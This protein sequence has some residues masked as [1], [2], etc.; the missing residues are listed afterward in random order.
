MQKGLIITSS[1]LS[2]CSIKDLFLTELKLLLLICGPSVLILGLWLIPHPGSWSWEPID[3]DFMGNT[4]ASIGWCL[5]ENSRTFIFILL[6]YQAGLLLFAC[7]QAYILKRQ[8][9][10][11]DNEYSERAIISASLYSILQSLILTSPPLFYFESNK[12]HLYFFVGTVTVFMICF[13]PLMLV[14]GR[15]GLMISNNA[16]NVHMSLGKSTSRGIGHVFSSSSRLLAGNQLS[17]RNLTRSGISRSTTDARR[18]GNSNNVVGWQELRRQAKE[19]G[20][21][22]S[23]IR[24]PEST[25]M[26]STV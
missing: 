17:M 16:S 9:T 15:I 7:T 4:D 1:R 2:G 22:T 20:N 12:P 5:Y 13:S 21:T 25:I 26:F 23:M 10:R 18:K 3:F 14:H 6:S 19:T 8:E 24:K 11:P